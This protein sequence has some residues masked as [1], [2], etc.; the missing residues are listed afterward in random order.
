MGLGRANLSGRAVDFPQHLLKEFGRRTACSRR[1]RA[2]SSA[3]FIREGTRI[4][5]AR[6]IDPPAAGIRH[7]ALSEPLTLGSVGYSVSAIEAP[8][9]NLIY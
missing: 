6:E 1:R 5:A 9:E 7:V 2:S 4:D 8:I 3:F